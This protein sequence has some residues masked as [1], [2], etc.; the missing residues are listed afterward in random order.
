MLKVEKND[1]TWYIITQSNFKTWNAGDV[2]NRNDIDHDRSG[3]K[4]KTKDG[5]CTIEK[6]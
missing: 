4:K 3:K 1:G 2:N 6:S 5:N